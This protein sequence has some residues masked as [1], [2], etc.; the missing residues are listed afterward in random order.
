MPVRE[1]VNNDVCK[2]SPINHELYWNS[3]VY[4]PSRSGWLRRWRPWCR[5]R[6]SAT[7]Q[8]SPR[9]LIFGSRRRMFGVPRLL[10]RT[11]HYALCAC[12]LSAMHYGCY[13]VRNFCAQLSPLSCA[14]EWKWSDQSSG[15]EEKEVHRNGKTQRGIWTVQNELQG[16]T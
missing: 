1:N 2:D 11:S 15:E 16:L 9:D 8:R 7:Y 12:F 13:Y 6:H 5:S 3:I 4:C 14:R 10:S